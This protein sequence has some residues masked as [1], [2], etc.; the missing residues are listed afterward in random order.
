M[1]DKWNIEYDIHI[2][3]YID[4]LAKYKVG[5]VVHTWIDGKC[6]SGI[7]RTRYITGINDSD[8]RYNIAVDSGA[9]VNVRED[10]LIKTGHI[11]VEASNVSILEFW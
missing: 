2:E 3:N 11:N 8:V 1:D 4:D 5:D 6:I 10:A 7:I 9:L